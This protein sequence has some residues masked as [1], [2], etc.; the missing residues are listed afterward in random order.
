MPT[1]VGALYGHE[2]A[3][4]IHMRRALYARRIQ[5]MPTGLQWMPLCF[6]REQEC[7]VCSLGV[8]GP[9]GVQYVFT[10]GVLDARGGEFG[11]RGL[12]LHSIGGD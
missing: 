11:D 5:Y 3:F 12:T 1:R 8:Q 9:A 6:Y 4:Y 7:I 2:A 10:G